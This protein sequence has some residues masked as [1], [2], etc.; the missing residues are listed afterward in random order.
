M[1]GKCIHIF[2]D[3][4]EVEILLSN[5]SSRGLFL[6]TKTDTEEEAKSLLKQAAKWTRD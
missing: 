6:V 3:P 4:D 2:C 5:L 1:A